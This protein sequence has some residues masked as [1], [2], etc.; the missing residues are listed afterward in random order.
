HTT[1]TPSNLNTLKFCELMKL[2]TLK[3][4]S[5]LRCRHTNDIFLAHSIQ[6]QSYFIITEL[7]NT[8]KV[9]VSPKIQTHIFLLEELLGHGLDMLILQKT[10]NLLD[11]Y[12]DM[13][14]NQRFRSKKGPNLMENHSS[15]KKQ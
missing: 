3:K 1:A 4:L 6:I 11:L 12:Y 13:I 2:T 9:L 5:L 10:T 7:K 14:A 8:P 15:N